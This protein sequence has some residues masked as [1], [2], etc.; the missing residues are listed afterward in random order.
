MNTYESRRKALFQG[1]MGILF[2][3]ALLFAS[4]AILADTSPPD[5]S[6]LF[7]DHLGYFPGE[8]VRISLPDGTHDVVVETPSASY[9]SVDAQD[10]MS[11]VPRGEGQYKVIASEAEDQPFAEVNFTVVADGSTR[12]ELKSIDGRPFTSDFVPLSGGV[13]VKKPQ[14][15]L[16]SFVRSVQ[17]SVPA[18]S[19]GMSALGLSP[20]VSVTVDVEDT[21]PEGPAGYKVKRAFYLAKS[22]IVA[23]ADVELEASGTRLYRCPATPSGVC[24]S[25][26]QEV[27]DI[28]PGSVYTLSP[29]TG[30]YLYAEAG[31][32]TVNTEKPM[33][34]PGETAIIWVAVLDSAG[35]PVSGADIILTVTEPFGALH[36][37]SSA[38]GE[39][40]EIRKGVYET[41]FLTSEE[42][43]HE[44]SAVASTSEGNS[45][46]E[47]SFEV[48][49]FYEFD[50]LR[51]APMIIDPWQ[52]S[53]RSSVT[54]EPFIAASS[55]TLVERLPAAFTLDDVGG[56]AISGEPGY[57]LLTWTGL[58][59]GEQVAY[60]V[61]APRV[62]PV[63]YAIGPIE[64]H[65]N[66][67]SFTEA[68]SWLI[69]ADPPPEQFG[70]AGWIFLQ[71]G[72]TQAP[73]GTYYSINDTTSGFFMENVT[74]IPFPGYSGRYSEVVTG[75]TND[76]IIVRAWNSSHWGSNSVVLTGDMDNV[77]VTFNMSRT[78]EPDVTVLSPADFTF[79]SV[80]DNFVLQ[81]ELTILGAAPALNCNATLTFT[82]ADVV[83]L[84]DGESAVQ[85]LENISLGT[86]LLLNWS[87]NASS[88]GTTDINIT[89]LCDDNS[90][91]FETLDY[92][93]A[94]G[95]QVRDATPPTP[96]GIA[97]WIFDTD[98]TTQ[99][100]LGTLYTINNTD[101]TFYMKNKTRIP[102]PGYTG[103]YS[104]TI[105]GNDADNITII[106]WNE[107]HW[108]RTNVTLDG[109][110]EGMNVSLN[111]SR[112]SELNISFVFPLNNSFYSAYDHFENVTINITNIGGLTG[113]NCSIT[114][115]ISNTSV[116]NI[117][118]TDSFTHQLGNISVGEA[119][120]SIWNVSI[121]P[122]DGR[123]STI[124][125]TANASCESD[126]I[127]FD[128]S[129][130][131]KVENITIESLADLFINE[132]LISFS[133]N[134]P[135][136]NVTL[137]INA[138]I[139]NLGNRNA[140]NVT[141]QFCVDNTSAENQLNGNFLLNI[142]PFSN[143]TAT[144]NWTTVTGTHEIIVLVDP[145]NA[146][147]EFNET[148][149]NASR[150][151]TIIA[152]QIYYGNLTGDILLSDAINT[153]T[154]RWNSTK[155]GNIFVVETGS[156]ITWASLLAI[157][158]NTTQGLQFEDFAEM[159]FLLN[160]SLYND[161]VN[162]T[163]TGAS[164][165][166]ELASYFIYGINISNVSVVNTTSNSAFQTGI[167]WDSSDD[168]SGNAT[169][170]T[171]DR[172]ELVFITT[173]SRNT[174]GQYG[175]YDYEIRVP[176]T[177]RQYK[178]SY[179]T[180][181]FYVELK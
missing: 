42:G 143:E 73:L 163:Y 171:G 32:S 16:L 90:T 144:V 100:P 168:T 149:N 15:P 69:A 121:Q 113:E 5:A 84:K 164:S 74:R 44:L 28:V 108:G 6:E 147:L 4:P 135:Q 139:F 51:D 48:A 68:R 1:A 14:K 49:A 169:F 2:L 140:S 158:R 85:F 64:I 132:T 134:S 59:P 33:Y 78:G 3:L 103:R 118:A 107:T 175:T 24:L 10:I 91:G 104:E 40:R 114:I 7:T 119:V 23:S 92:D 150:N 77:N 88:K 96:H 17:T 110:I 76:I 26:W 122:F 159:D 167:L 80:A 22:T 120:L 19:G 125:I 21:P 35:F 170:D 172:E 181:S 57:W 151:I 124:F 37:L 36:V 156:D 126:G 75:N 18:Q 53:F 30:L 11:F 145:E 20:E 66:T 142:S 43:T 60:Y 95:I 93:A 154:L 41:V 79:Y 86:E 105:D 165:P 101:S 45:Y 128:E 71:D 115:N 38:A 34:H 31:I 46:I 29:S 83:T 106:S 67:A 55:F 72:A 54:V 62:S 141:V 70:L 82:T 155:G 153:S 25:P 111:T 56:A 123:N 160:M 180:V 137:W 133:D 117:I 130:K 177:L 129:D 39:I 99:V 174:A 12:V 166:K 112:P 102:F 116:V 65:Y 146:T 13:V 173:I 27:M 178:Y 136:E 52:G 161:S 89:I 138:T 131:A 157:G 98:W 63:M 9:R 148:N 109:D 94:K 162:Q 152:W 87:L 176:A 47:S 50:I 61:S 97:G 58:S 81:A 179:G 127:N 8:T